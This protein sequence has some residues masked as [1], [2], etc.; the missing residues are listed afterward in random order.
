MIDT[1]KK[2]FGPKDSK[3]DPLAL[4]NAKIAGLQDRCKLYEQRALN[5]E[6]AHA[7]V[8]RN[9]QTL[10]KALHEKVAECDELRPDAERYRAQRA[11]ASLN[12]KQFRKPAPAASVVALS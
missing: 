2:M 3:P 11:K 7:R 10:G 12:L 6:S 4:A 9:N 5:A 8:Q 1:W